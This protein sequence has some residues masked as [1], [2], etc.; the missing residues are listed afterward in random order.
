MV[1]LSIV[2]FI[3]FILP[4]VGDSDKFYFLPSRFFEITIGGIAGY[5]VCN[6]NGKIKNRAWIIINFCLLIA[7]LLMGSLVHDNTILIIILL[8]WDVYFGYQKTIF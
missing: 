5:V 6:L 4:V 1:I 3:I 8:Y 2:S 7:V